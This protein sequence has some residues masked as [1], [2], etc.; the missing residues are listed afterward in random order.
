MFHFFVKFWLIYISS[1][2]F[3]N[4]QEAVHP[5][6]NIVLGKAE[7]ALDYFKALPECTFVHD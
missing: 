2:T 1:D 3:H 4:E 5:A 7:D 6:F